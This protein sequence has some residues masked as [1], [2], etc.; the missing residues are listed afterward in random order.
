MISI[1]GKKIKPDHTTPRPGEVKEFNCDNT[2]ALKLG[3]K[4]DTDFDK[5][6]KEYI[7]WKTKSG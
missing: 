3:W 2:K 1:F 4:P 5:L 7:A 6:L